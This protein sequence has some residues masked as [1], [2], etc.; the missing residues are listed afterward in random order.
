MT[1]RK[2]IERWETKVRNCEF[3]PHA[4]AYCKIAYEKEWTKGTNHC[5]WT[6]RNNISPKRESQC[7]WGLFRKPVHISWPM[8]QKSWAT[9]GH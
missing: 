9:G 3:T 2:A 6:F 4:L 7:D 8:L 5:A 1:R